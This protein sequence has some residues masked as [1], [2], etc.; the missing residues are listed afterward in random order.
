MDIRAFDVVLVERHKI[1]DYLLSPV[2]T[3]GQFKAEFFQSL[4]YHQLLW[5]LLERDLRGV[6]A[7]G[8]QAA[9]ESDFGTKY[10]ASGLITGPNG[11]QAWV[12][13]V[14]IV[15]PATNVLRFVTAYPED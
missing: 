10:T 13:T 2:H 15:Q 4:G 3:V 14:W 6:L 8:L 11:K 1:L 5:R 12:L 7:N 9:G